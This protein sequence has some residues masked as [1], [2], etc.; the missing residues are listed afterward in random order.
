MSARK[1]MFM[2]DYFERDGEVIINGTLIAPDKIQVVKHN[3]IKTYLLDFSNL[4]E[5]GIGSETEFYDVVVTGHRRKNTILVDEI[6]DSPEE[7]GVSVYRLDENRQIKWVF[8]SGVVDMV[9]NYNFAKKTLRIL[10]GTG[11]P[12]VIDGFG[13]LDI[14]ETTVDFY[15]NDCPKLFVVHDEFRQSG[16]EETS[17]I[18]RFN[19]LQV[20]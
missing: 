9:P 19:S 15:K 6:I 16:S 13:R 8:A 7:T 20:G 14:I 5:R 2:T 11:T 1:G 12:V 17:K 3:E 4:Y 10:S 18:L